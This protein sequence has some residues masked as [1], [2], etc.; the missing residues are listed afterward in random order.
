MFIGAVLGQ[1]GLKIDAVFV[2]TASLGGQPSLVC[3]ATELLLLPVRFYGYGPPSPFD[4]LF[5]SHSGDS[6]LHCLRRDSYFRCW[7]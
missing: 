7:V 6:R 3:L 5:F 2:H 1:L 4:S